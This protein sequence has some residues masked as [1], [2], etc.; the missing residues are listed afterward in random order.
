MTVSNEDM[1]AMVRELPIPFPWDRN[2]FIQ[3]IA[4]MRGRPI[5]LIP[6]DTAT[7]EGSPCGLWLIREH[8]DLILHEV[9]TSEYHVDQIVCHEIG[10]MVLGHGRDQTIDPDR[11]R[12]QSLRNKV[13]AEVDPDSVQA[14]LGRTNYAT[15][16][17]RDAEM[18]A[19]ILMIAAADTADERSVMR[20]V[21]LRR[22]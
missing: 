9:G 6:V 17:E 2:V 14:V 21:F 5:H 16:Q 22:R 20:G 11:N 19:N 3:R 1:L 8:D 10:H 18:F 7:L 12:E 13:L 4:E 15:D